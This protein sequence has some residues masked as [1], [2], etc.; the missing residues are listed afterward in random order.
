MHEGKGR[1]IIYVMHALSE[2]QSHLLVVLF[3]AGNV[4][5][6]REEKCGFI[7]TDDSNLYTRDL[8]PLFAQGPHSNDKNICGSHARLT[9]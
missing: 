9:K 3:F 5:L 4:L 7:Y 2:V 8:Q 1:H 6:I